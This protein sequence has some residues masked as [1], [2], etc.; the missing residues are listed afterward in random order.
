VLPFFTLSLLFFIT[1]NHPDPRRTH[2]FGRIKKGEGRNGK[3]RFLAS[4]A[5]GRKKNRKE[6][7]EQE[8]LCLAID[9]ELAAFLR[10]VDN[11]ETSSREVRYPAY[12][13]VLKKHLTLKNS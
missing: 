12:N 2:Q 1:N 7:M 9:E 4:R 6:I 11:Y 13:P 8:D 3:S 10:C 5:T